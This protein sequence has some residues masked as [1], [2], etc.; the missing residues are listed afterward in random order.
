MKTVS[1]RWKKTSVSCN[2]RISKKT[3]CFGC[4][5]NSLDIRLKND[6]PYYFSEIALINFRSYGRYSLKHNIGTNFFEKLACSLLSVAT[7]VLENWNEHNY[8]WLPISGLKNHRWFAKPDSGILFTQLFSPNSS[9]WP[10][11][12]HNKKHKYLYLLYFSKIKLPQT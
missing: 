9:K 10:G 3:H 11:N 5:W 8:F 1:Y 4:F 12:W 7:I 6:Q 2:F